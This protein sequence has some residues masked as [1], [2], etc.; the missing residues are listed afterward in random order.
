MSQEHLLSDA[1]TESVKSNFHN[2][3]V[4]SSSTPPSFHI[5]EYWIIFEDYLPVLLLCLFTW[6]LL[7]VISLI[8]YLNCSLDLFLLFEAEA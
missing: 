1:T 3:A 2:T 8:D 6:I 5:T 7:L 4:H